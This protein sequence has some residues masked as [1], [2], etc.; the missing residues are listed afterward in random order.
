M[1]EQA[2]TMGQVFGAVLADAGVFKWDEAGRGALGS[3]LASL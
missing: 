1:P 2:L 3:F